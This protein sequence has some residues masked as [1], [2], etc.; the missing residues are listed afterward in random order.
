MECSS[1]ITSAGVAALLLV[2]LAY[3]GWYLYL[4]FWK[5]VTPNVPAKHVSST[6]APLQKL[7]AKPQ[8]E[9]FGKL[10]A[11]QPVK[12]PVTQ[13][14]K[15]RL[16]KKPQPKSLPA[17]PKAGKAVKPIIMKKPPQSQVKTAKLKQLQQSH[18]VVAKAQIR[19]QVKKR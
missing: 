3:I 12:Q 10:K 18:A 5:K 13:A 17:Q 1:L 6:F 19:K 16:Q 8:T 9:T 4:V 2:V 15:S 14:G 11:K 7:G